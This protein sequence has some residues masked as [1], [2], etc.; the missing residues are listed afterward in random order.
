MAENFAQ[1]AII[2]W[3]LA[4]VLDTNTVQFPIQSSGEEWN[5]IPFSELCSQNRL[6]NPREFPDRKHRLS[7]IV[8]SSFT[9]EVFFNQ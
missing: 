6:L 2:Y 1:D 3:E 8:A 5:T 4:C 7:V 9:V